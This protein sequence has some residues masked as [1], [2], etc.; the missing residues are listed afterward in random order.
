MKFTQEQIEE[1]KSI[2]N[3]DDLLRIFK[4]LIYLSNV[5][6]KEL[7]NDGLKGCYDMLDDILQ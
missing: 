6:Y 1:I 3:I 2:D 5:S 4:R 7:I